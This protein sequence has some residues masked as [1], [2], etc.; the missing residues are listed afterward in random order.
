MTF[1]VLKSQIPEN[2]HELVLEH[3]RLMMDHR[4]TVNKPAPQCPVPF[5]DQ[6][7]RKIRP[8]P[9]GA[10][11]YVVDYRVVDDTPP[12]PPEPTPPNLE[13]KK[14]KLLLEVQKAEQEL[15]DAKRPPHGKVRLLQIKASNAQSKGDEAT[16]DEKQALA[17]LRALN[18]LQD[19]VNLKVAEIMSDIEDLT[20]ENIDQWV[21]P[22]LV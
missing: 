21:M 2:F 1:A 11:E 18:E 8:D 6:C 15:L 14:L 17:D 19:A 5:V 3:R 4:A 10:D 9:N 16:D 12:P 20:E 22:P 13:E 7:V